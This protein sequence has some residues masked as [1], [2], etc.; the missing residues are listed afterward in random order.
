VRRLLDKSVV[1]TGASAGVG[2]AAARAF[3]LAGSNVALIARGKDG[4]DATRR[5]ITG[6]GRRALAI[7]ADV[8]DHDQV[9]E[10]ADRIERE[11]GGVDVWVNNAMAS[12]LSPVLDTTPEEFR[13]VMEVTYLGCVHGTLSALRRM[14]PRDRGV[15]IQVGSALAYR[16]IPLQAAYCA[17]KHALKGF[18]ESLRC[19]LLHDRSR[20]RVTMVHL[21]ALNTPQFGW[22]RTRM[23]RRPQPVPPIYQPEVAARAIV[24]AACHPRRELLVGGPTL[25]AILAERFVPD[26]ADRVLARSAYESQQ[27]D[28]PVEPGRRDNL[29][30]PVPGDHGPHGTF[31]ARA[32][33]SSRLLWLETHRGSIGAAVLL[34]ASSAWLARSRQVAIH[35]PD[36][37]PP[38]G[39]P[40]VHDVSK[41]VDS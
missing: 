34:A 14:V 9:E 1:I 36:V 24:W 30:N 23:P 2:R 40:W 28:G 19:E 26:I 38:S 18:T 16:S 7:A 33:R 25:K 11:W 27:H 4:L 29:W 41:G 13:R 39:T 3:A 37:H 15:I 8:A 12:V 10:A 6:L 20:V 31:G 21:P 22:I 32:R 5:E 35:D 17:A